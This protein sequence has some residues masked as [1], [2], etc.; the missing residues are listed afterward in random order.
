MS[1]VWLSDQDSNTLE[2]E[3]TIN[4]LTLGGM[5]R[6]FKILDYVG[7]NGGVIKGFG[8]MKSRKFKVAR[9]EKVEGSDN[10]FFNSRRLD[11]TSWFTRPR[12]DTIYLNI[13]NGEDTKTYRT[14]VYTM[15]IGSDKSGN[16]KIT[17]MRSMTLESPSGVFDNITATTDTEAITGGTEASVAIANGGILETSIIC[18]FT[19]SANATIYQ[20][21]AFDTYGFRLEGSFNSGVE[22]SLDTSDGTLLIDSVEQKLSQ[23][24]TSGG[25]F[26][27][28]PGSNTLKVYSDASGTFDY[29]FNER[30][31]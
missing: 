30:V 23:Y 20:V 9:K 12:T 1:E 5:K 14:Q 3:S 8:T 11:Y 16:L 17:D 2:L 15:D 10:N 18:N 24:L 7:T 22:I 13:R 4:E 19:P 29:S 28:N 31:I 27:I 21:I 26:N 6:N 25:L